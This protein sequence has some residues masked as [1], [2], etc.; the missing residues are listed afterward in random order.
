ML[1]TRTL[2]RPHRLPRNTVFVLLAVL[3]G[4]G[5][6]G[7]PATVS[8]GVSSSEPGPEEVVRYETF[9]VDAYAELDNEMDPLAH[10]V[11]ESLMRSVAAD[12]ARYVQT[13]Q[14]FRIQIHS[15]LDRATAVEAEQ[16]VKSWWIGIP[17]EERPE[18]VFGGGLPVYL[19]YAQPYYRVRV[20]NFA[21]RDE[22]EL[23]LT[24]VQEEFSG[25]FIALDRISVLR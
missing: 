25:A 7:A 24:L 10:D 6:A 12:G 21:T 8:D 3:T 18:G 22:A 9:A 15:S 14:G 4:W 2:H 23:A 17:L 20:G 13:I 16:R 19:K 11:P 1:A 5:C